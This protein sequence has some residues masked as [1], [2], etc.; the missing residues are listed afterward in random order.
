MKEGEIAR[1]F[2]ALQAVNVPKLS[3]EEVYDIFDD[4]ASI[5]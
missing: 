1:A 5:P 2:R 4:F 3:S